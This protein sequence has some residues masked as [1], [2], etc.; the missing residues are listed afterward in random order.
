MRDQEPMN[1]AREE[2]NRYYKEY[3]AKNKEKIREINK[4]YWERKAT[5]RRN[6]YAEASST[7]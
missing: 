1:A 2:R 4:R 7:E 5:K 6:E 3:R